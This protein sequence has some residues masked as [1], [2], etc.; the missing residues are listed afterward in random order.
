MSMSKTSHFG[1]VLPSFNL[2]DAT[3][4]DK[5]HST[6]TS[7]I[8]QIFMIIKSNSHTLSFEMGMCFVAVHTTAV[9]QSK[10]VAASATRL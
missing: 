10:P 1:A 5:Q 2:R 4:E 9:E 7:P 8:K 6:N 3:R